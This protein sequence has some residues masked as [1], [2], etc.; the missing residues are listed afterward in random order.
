MFGRNVIIIILIDEIRAKVEKNFL[1]GAIAGL[2]CNI[3]SKETDCT[4]HSGLKISSHFSR[5]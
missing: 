5:F 2:F 3:F 4:A 1:S